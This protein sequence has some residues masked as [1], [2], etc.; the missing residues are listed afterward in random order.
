MIL[1]TK[2]NISYI[3]VTEIECDTTKQFVPCC[4]GL[5]RTVSS[6]IVPKY[7]LVCLVHC[8]VGLWTVYQECSVGLLFQLGSSRN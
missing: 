3:T 7:S 8:C 6:C 2:I 1:E 4:S 5:C